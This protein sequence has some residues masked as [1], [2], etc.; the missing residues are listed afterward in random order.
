MKIAELS[1]KTGLS[2]TALHAI[3]HEKTK[4]IAYDT[5]DKICRALDCTLGKLLEYVPETGKTKE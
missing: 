2:Y 1:R 4:F 3:Y 5:M